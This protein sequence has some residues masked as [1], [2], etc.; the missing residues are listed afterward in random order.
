MPTDSK[1]SPGSA[2]DCK[3]RG[4]AHEQ[5]LLQQRQLSAAAMILMPTTKATAATAGVASAEAG[6]G[7]KA[8]AGKAAGAAIE[9]KGWTAEGQQVP[10]HKVVKGGMSPPFHLTPLAAF[11]LTNKLEQLHE[12]DFPAAAPATAD[13]ADNAVATDDAQNCSAGDHD[14]ARAESAADTACNSMQVD[15]LGHTGSLPLLRQLMQGHNDPLPPLLPP[16]ATTTTTTATTT[17][18]MGHIGPLPQLPQLK[19]RKVLVPQHELYSSMYGAAGDAD[20]VGCPV[21]LFH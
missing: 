13:N 6:R 10:E 21:E 4:M 18:A 12:P 2:A 16:T 17:T 14:D 11:M 5:E 15:V 8:G 19:Q 9:L 7:A 1:G 20:E 3:Y